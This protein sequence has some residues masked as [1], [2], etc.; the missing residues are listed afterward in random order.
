MQ[1]LGKYLA[2]NSAQDHHLNKHKGMEDEVARKI[3]TETKIDICAFSRA[4][5]LLA[6]IIRAK[7]FEKKTLGEESKVDKRFVGKKIVLGR[8]T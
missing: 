7:K 5:T 6:N 3:K 1:S 4:I 2:Q 8:A